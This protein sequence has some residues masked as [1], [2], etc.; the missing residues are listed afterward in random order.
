MFPTCKGLFVPDGA[1]EFCGLNDDEAD[2]FCGL[3]DEFDG[4][5]DD[6]L[7]D[8]I[9]RKFR[10]LE[11]ASNFRL[12]LSENASTDGSGRRGDVIFG[13]RSAINCEATGREFCIWNRP[14]KP[15]KP[16]DELSPS[17]RR[18]FLS[19]SFKKRLGLLNSIFPYRQRL[20]AQ[21]R[22]QCFSARVTAT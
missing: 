5:K 4:L 10:P 7:D 17:T 6:E 1:D 3:N 9:R 14:P 20:F 21:V 11:A 2:G 19:M 12:K 22:M 18:N 16:P 8:G 15:P 13:C